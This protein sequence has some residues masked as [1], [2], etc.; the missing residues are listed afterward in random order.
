MDVWRSL[1]PNQ[2][3]FSFID[4]TKKG[5][6]SRIDLWL[7]PKPSLQH[8]KSCSFV[9]APTPDHKAISLDIQFYNKERGKGYWKL[10]NSVLNDEEYKQ[11]I[12]ELYNETDMQYEGQVSN[13]LLWEFLKVKIKQ[14]SIGLSYCVM[15]SR[16]TQNQIRELEKLLDLIDILTT[17]ELVNEETRLERKLLKQELNS[18]YEQKAAGCQERSRAQWVEKGGKSTS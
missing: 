4:P 12:A 7:V 11:G 3:G 13:T 18:M 6:D 9:Q 16:T 10:N 17:T 8:V 1:H 2:K 14:F 15:K 5:H